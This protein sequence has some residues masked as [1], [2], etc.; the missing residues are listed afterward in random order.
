MNKP[1][2]VLLLGMSLF[3]SGLAKANEN[4]GVNLGDIR[5]FEVHQFEK[6]DFSSGR[7]ELLPP[8]IAEYARTA[9][10]NDER[11]TY[12]SPGEGVLHFSCAS[13]QC[14]RIQV[15]LTHGNDGPVVW[16]TSKRFRPLV[17]LVEPD[18]R[19]FA[20][21]IVN[22]LAEEYQNSLKEIPA[23]IPLNND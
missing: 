21:V 12:Q 1:T 18:A 3:I 10:Q 7:E 5:T 6:N 22:Q 16:K 13:S 15:E 8:E 9:I 19:Q 11:L 14:G 20:K 2:I 23:K 4:A 17:T